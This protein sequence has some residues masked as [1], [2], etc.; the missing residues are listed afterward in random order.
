MQLK[1]SLMLWES[2]WISPSDPLVETNRLQFT[3]ENG[4]YSVWLSVRAPSG[5]ILYTDDP[6]DQ[7]AYF[8]HDLVIET[9]LPTPNARVIQ[10]L[11]D[12]EI[13]DE[14]KE[15]YRL[16]WVIVSTTYNRFAG[17]V[18]NVLK[19]YWLETLPVDP[20]SPYVELFNSCGHSLWLDEDGKWRPLVFE[21][22]MR[23]IGDVGLT[24]YSEHE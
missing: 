12:G 14:L 22:P 13:T 6:T 20:V 15:F 21:P 8:W 3:I 5:N 4:I 7:T 24:Y 23:R 1:I 9:D 11:R 17:Y 16:V 10:A 18:R 2:L 19:Q